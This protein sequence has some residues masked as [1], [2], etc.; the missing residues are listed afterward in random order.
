M[1]KVVGEGCWLTCICRSPLPS[2]WNPPDAGTPP[3]G[4]PIICARWVRYMPAR[5]E[6][7][8]ELA[9]VAGIVSELLGVLGRV[10]DLVLVAVQV[11]LP[12]ERW[13][14]RLITPAGSISFLLRTR[15]PALT[16]R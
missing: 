16:I 15:K 10:L 13:S 7:V 5:P 1:I 4:T 8:A 12:L 3:H 9:V 14:M 6:V 11:D 2:A